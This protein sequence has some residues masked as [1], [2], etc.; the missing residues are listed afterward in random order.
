MI[1]AKASINKERPSHRHH[2]AGPDWSLAW[3]KYAQRSLGRHDWPHGRGRSSNPVYDWGQGC[4]LVV[5][6]QFE[7]F[8]GTLNTTN[9]YHNKCIKF[10]E[11]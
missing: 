2:Q 7:I 1:W 3:Q 9:T 5:Y 10:Y 6:F 11:T 8:F 4:A